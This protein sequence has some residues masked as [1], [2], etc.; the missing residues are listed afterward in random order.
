MK[1]KNIVV[2][3]SANMDLIMRV[4]R[5]PKP[6]ESLL[7]THFMTAHGGKGAN[8]AV[9]AARLGANVT[10]VGCVGT[11]AFGALQREGFVQE[12]ISVAHLKTSAQEPTGTALILLT[13][14]GQ[15]AIVVAPAANYDLLPQDISGLHDLFAQADMIISQLEI[16]I[17]SVAITL[18]LARETSTFSLLDAGPARTVAPELLANADMVSPNETEAEA[19]TGIV[20]DSLDAA[21]QSAKKLCAMGVEHVVLKLG[22]R[23]CL[24]YGNGEEL[25][26]PAFAITAVDTTAAGDAFTGAL[27]VAWGNMPLHDALR[28]ANA[29]GALAATVEGAQP[30]IPT[31]AA[32]LHFLEERNASVSET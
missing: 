3:G 32:V 1:P 7:G 14:S 4:S 10:F 17:E 26:V 28:F 2:V 15:N 24:Y 11:D 21:R 6:G 20:V 19:L 25:V 5:L 18:R 13:E 29:A 23:G 31:R 9:A 8:Q 30:S 12:G 22:A 27:G 16:P